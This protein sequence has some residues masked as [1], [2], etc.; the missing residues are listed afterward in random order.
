M[1][2]TIIFLDFDDIPAYKIL[3]MRYVE[4]CKIINVTCN[5]SPAVFG[6][7]KVHAKVVLTGDD[8][9]IKRFLEFVD[10]SMAM[11]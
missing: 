5:V 10:E 11:L 7:G 2:E 1:S 9:D 4:I 3:S 6:E 8:I